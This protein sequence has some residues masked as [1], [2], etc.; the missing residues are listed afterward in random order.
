MDGADG[1]PAGWLCLR[2]AGGS[3]PWAHALDDAGD[4]RRLC[5][6]IILSAGVVAGAAAGG[7]RAGGR[8]DHYRL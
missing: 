6:N 4:R 3:V 5:A 2:S 7:R 8:G 1:V